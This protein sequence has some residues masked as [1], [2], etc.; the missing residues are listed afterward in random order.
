MFFW[1][2]IS[3]RFIN[4]YFLIFFVYWRLIKTILDISLILHWRTIHFVELVLC[5]IIVFCFLIFL[6]ES[7]LKF[8]NPL[9]WN[10]YVTL[11]MSNQ[12]IINGISDLKK[13]RMNIS[14]RI[15]MK[16]NEFSVAFFTRYVYVTVMRSG[17]P[18]ISRRH[19]ES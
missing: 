3:L 8:W 18:I 16:T 9:G 15:L 6:T 1:L 11:S 19:R 13:L 10:R 5:V 14:N 17:F 7:E 2:N 4:Y 12:K